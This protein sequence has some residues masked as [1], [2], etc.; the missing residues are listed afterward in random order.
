MT[1]QWSAASAAEPLPQALTDV[2]VRLAGLFGGRVAAGSD[3][4]HRLVGNDEAGNLIAGHAVEPDLDLTI[5]DLERLIA[6]AFLER[7]T[8]A[9]D[10][11]QLGAERGDGPPIHE[12]VGIVEEP[13]ALGVPDDH[14]LRARLAHHCGAD[15]AGER[16]LLLPVQVLSRHPNVRVASGFGDGMQRGE[17]R[18]DDD[19]D[20]DDV[21]HHAAELFDEHDR[22][23]DGLVHLPVGGDE[24]DAHVIL[25]C[26]SR[27]AAQRLAASI[28]NLHSAFSIRHCSTYLIATTPGSCCPPR[29][30]SD[31]PPPVEM[32]V[33]RSVTPALAT[34]AIESPPPMTVVPLTAATAFATSSV[35]FANASISNTPIGPFQI[36]VFAPGDDV[37]VNLHGLWPDVE[38]HPLADGGIADVERLRRRAGF[39]LWRDDVID[40][41][42]E[43]QAALLGPPLDVTRRV[44][45]FGFDERLADGQIPRL[46]E[47]VRHRAADEQRVDARDQVL[48]DLELVRNLRAA[49]NRDKRT[50]RILE[51]A[52]EILDL[53]RHQQAGSRLGDVM[54]DAFG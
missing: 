12:L 11:R 7:L 22:L 8:D 32:W 6:F 38:A 39:E 16:A 29:N 18:R 1:W 17:R 52:A 23:V 13:A 34:A 41:E 50:V 37:A 40:G 4:P 47:R 15:L 33:M 14:V 2:R 49:E 43:A 25:I 19:L 36:T 31:A 9:D 26:C 24:R 30:S 48:D 5:E 44:E 28:F 21:L 3:G 27:L 20:V 46:E 53:L 45:L 10:W 35:P 42:L 54:D 51:H